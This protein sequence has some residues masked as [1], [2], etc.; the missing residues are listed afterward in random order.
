MK[1]LVAD[2]K[3]KSQLLQKD[4]ENVEARKQLEQ[5]LTNANIENQ[6]LAEQIEW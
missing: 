4:F 2:K 6:A 1:F 5:Q 3:Q